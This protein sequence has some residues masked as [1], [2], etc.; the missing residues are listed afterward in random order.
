VPA[1]AKLG[2][3][4][5]TGRPCICASAGKAWLQWGRDRVS[6]FASRLHAERDPSYLLLSRDLIMKTFLSFSIFCW[7]AVVATV[8]QAERPNIIMFLI[9]DQNPS[10]IAAFGGDTRAIA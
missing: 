1:L 8:A 3:N 10:S 9:D 6:G 5:E 4:G 2:F 7:W